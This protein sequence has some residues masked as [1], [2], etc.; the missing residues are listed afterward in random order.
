LII[1]HII[2]AIYL[3]H[4]GAVVHARLIDNILQI[5]SRIVG[6]HQAYERGI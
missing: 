5:T 1:F 3:A 6:P 4:Y 2:L